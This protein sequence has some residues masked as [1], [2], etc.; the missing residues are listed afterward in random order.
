MRSQNINK[1]EQ[2]KTPTV[3]NV[4]KQQ[5][6]GDQAEKSEVMVSSMPVRTINY[7]E[8]GSMSHEQ[9]A[10]LGKLFAANY[11]GNVH[12]PH[13]LIPVR[14]GKL[15]TDINFENEVLPIVKQLCEVAN[16]EIV[17]RG[18]DVEVKVIRNFVDGSPE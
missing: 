4:S 3:I 17:M 6:I 10:E 8:V 9:I 14:D 5:M 16:G 2:K 7:V 11:Q 15:R 12:G 18:A 1:P 13:Y